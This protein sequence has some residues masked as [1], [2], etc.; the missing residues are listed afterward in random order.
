MGQRGEVNGYTKAWWTGVTT[1]TLAKAIESALEQEITGLYHLTN[2]RHI[3]K[4][5]L[6]RLFSKYFRENRVI[7]VPYDEITV[8]KS[9][10]NNRHDF[11]FVVPGYEEMICEMKKWI[12]AHRQ[13]YPHYFNTNGGVSGA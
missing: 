11:S 9:L 5:E 4:Y 13:L 3:S 6:L 10:V 2:N 1:V 8:D 12:E 7:V